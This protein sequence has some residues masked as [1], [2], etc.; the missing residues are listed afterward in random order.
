[1]RNALIAV[2]VAVLL[3]VGYFYVQYKRNE[4]K[5]LGASEIAEE[6]FKKDGKIAN[7]KYV[8]VI[9]API[10]KVQDLVWGVE[11]TAGVLENIKKSELIKQEGD[12]KTV[13]IQLQA[14][15][16]PVQ[17]YVMVFTLDAPHHTVNFKTTQAQ[18]AD[19]EGSY[20]LEAR[21]DKTIL[22]YEAV[23][24]DKIAVPFPDGVIQGANREV[25]V[26]M[27]RGI[28][29]QAGGAPLPTPAS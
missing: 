29:K 27:V 9:N 6:S 3:V 21:G 28:T 18:A 8:G 4:A 19:L 14:S 16:L 13:L 20:K 25:F 23:S 22:T 12:T 24:T 11:K 5:Y 2:V 15:T 17:Q 10:D 26:N 7:I 1:M